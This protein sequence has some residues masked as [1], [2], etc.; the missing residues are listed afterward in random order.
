MTV[1]PPLT[2]P[3]NCIS[4]S[5]ILAFSA[6]LGP[7]PLTYLSAQHAHCTRQRV[8]HHDHGCQQCRGDP[9]VALSE[10]LFGM[11]KNVKGLH[12]TEITDGLLPSYWHSGCQEIICK[13][14]YSYFALCIQECGPTQTWVLSLAWT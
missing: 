2:A 6:A 7:P 12:C 4:F 5:S 3:M 1:L 9:Q 11:D 13:R 10:A 8:N 14:L